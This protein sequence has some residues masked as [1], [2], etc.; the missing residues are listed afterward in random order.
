[1][2]R[3]VRSCRRRIGDRCPGVA[4]SD[5]PLVA[6]EL[7]PAVSRRAATRAVRSCWANC[8]RI[9]HWQ[10]GPRRSD[11]TSQFWIDARSKYP[12]QG[13]HCLAAFESTYPSMGGEHGP[14][15]T[16]SYRNAHLGDLGPHYCHRH[17]IDS[18]RSGIR[19]NLK[20]RVQ[21]NLRT[22]RQEQ[23][24]GPAEGP[25]LTNREH[26][27]TQVGRGRRCG[28]ERCLACKRRWSSMRTVWSSGGT[29]RGSGMGPSVP[30]GTGATQWARDSAQ[31][32]DGAADDFVMDAHWWTQPHTGGSP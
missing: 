25:W 19:Q 32:R 31:Q 30:D 8:S 14:L 16:S 21:L 26:I 23:I 12:S 22:L 4:P 6:P 28:K 9:P 10:R 20:I 3:I 2:G 29:Q 15:I 13:R 17:R 18:H 24:E 11:R 7:P 1:M 5:D 27:G